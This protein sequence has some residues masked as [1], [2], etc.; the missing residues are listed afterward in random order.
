MMIWHKT[1][2]KEW[3]QEGHWLSF[4]FLEAGEKSPT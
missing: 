1:L 2:E 3:V 4:F